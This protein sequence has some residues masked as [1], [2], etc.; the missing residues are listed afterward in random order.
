LVTDTLVLVAG[1]LVVE[2]V[3]WYIHPTLAAKV[4][5]VAVDL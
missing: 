4:D 5:W 3:M 1:V 2:A